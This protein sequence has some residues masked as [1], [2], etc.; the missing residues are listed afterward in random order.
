ME[1]EVLPAQQIVQLQKINQTAPILSAPNEVN[2]LII[3]HYLW[4]HIEKLANVIDEVETYR[5]YTKYP[6]YL[7]KERI[8]SK[9][10]KEIALTMN[11]LNNLLGT[12][13][14]FS[15]III[16]NPHIGSAIRYY[17]T[18]VANPKHPKIDY[19]TNRDNSKFF[20][21]DIRGE[22]DKL[23]RSALLMVYH[24]VDQD[25]SKAKLQWLYNFGYYTQVLRSPIPIG[26]KCAVARAFDKAGCKTTMEMAFQSGQCAFCNLNY[27]LHFHTRATPELV[28]IA[29][30]QGANPNEIMQLRSCQHHTEDGD[31]TYGLVKQMPLTH[32]EAFLDDK[33]E[34][35]E[36][37]E[38]A[39]Q[40]AKEKKID[41]E[42]SDYYKQYQNHV[43]EYNKI[44]EMLDKRNAKKSSASAILVQVRNLTRFFS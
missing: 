31:D 39:E 37:L 22:H 10:N 6:Q 27:T 3:N 14:E 29:L 36:W 12:S 40:D 2:A 17:I 23:M 15:H 9:R 24:F 5:D 20:Y 11:R 18:Q 44:K 8:Y 19:E 13:R 25:K 42:E 4:G 26:K 35:K 7:L 33:K 1:K 38:Y 16:K 34:E 28:Q 30:E 32:I 43:K 41:L 21:K